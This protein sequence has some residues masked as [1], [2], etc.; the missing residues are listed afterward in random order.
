M[1]KV[2]KSNNITTLFLI[3]RKNVQDSCTVFL[4]FIFVIVLDFL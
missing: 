3:F 1:W 4:G 2:K